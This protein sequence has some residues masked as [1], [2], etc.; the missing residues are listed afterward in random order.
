MHRVQVL[1][2]GGRDILKM[3]CYDGLRC[4]TEAGTK[5]ERNEGYC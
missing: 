5:A 2:S 1:N 3:G 4:A